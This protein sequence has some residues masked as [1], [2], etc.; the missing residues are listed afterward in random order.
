MSK[1]YLGA[2]VV[3]AVLAVGA[4]DYINQAKMAGSRPGA[5]SA[6]DYAASVS[7]RLAGRPAG[8]AAE[9]LAAA[10]PGPA[11]GAGKPGEGDH[12]T[13]QPGEAAGGDIPAEP[14]QARADVKVNALGAGPCSKSGLGKRCS[15]GD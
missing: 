15:V 2:F 4:A 13:A 1:A 3:V 10:A 8:T 14:A 11:G 7:G 6:G 5:F 12:T 9:T